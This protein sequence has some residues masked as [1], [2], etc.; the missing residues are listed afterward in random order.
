MTPLILGKKHVK[1]LS[2]MIPDM[3]PTDVINSNGIRR[4][5]YP[6]TAVA[7]IV[8]PKLIKFMNLRSNYTC[9]IEMIDAKTDS[10]KHNDTG[11]G[12]DGT[13]GEGTYGKGMPSNPDFRGPGNNKGF[14]KS[15]STETKNTPAKAVAKATA[16]LVVKATAMQNKT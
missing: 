4:Y 11:T 12:R 8:G 5:S 9:S 1:H 13:F 7:H 15:D 16:K 14:K 2:A 10:H 3:P 6:I